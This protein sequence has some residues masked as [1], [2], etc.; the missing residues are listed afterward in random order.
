MVYLSAPYGLGI[1]RR[2]VPVVARLMA[3]LTRRLMPVEVRG[4]V[5]WMLNRTEPGWLITL[6]NPA[7]GVRII[8]VR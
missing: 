5:E 8:E 1:D 6:L 2:A 4:D 3:H 7:G